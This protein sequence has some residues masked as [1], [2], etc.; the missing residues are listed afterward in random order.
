[1]DFKEVKDKAEKWTNSNQ[2]QLL[3]SIESEN[4][5]VFNTT[6]GTHVNFWVTLPDSGNIAWVSVT[7]A[8]MSI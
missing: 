2:F 3:D 4:K 1:M 7:F 5:L 6:D 8:L